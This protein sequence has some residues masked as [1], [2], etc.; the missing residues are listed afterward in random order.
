MTPGRTFTM[1]RTAGALIL[2]VVG[3]A[4]VVLAVYLYALAA[5]GGGAETTPVG[6]VV[7]GSVGGLVGVA[8]L[9][10]AWHA[11]RGPSPT[12][13]GRFRRGA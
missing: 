10:F 6:L 12:R 7:Y 11:I 9:L 4:V 13:R 2:G 5:E 8:F 1:L 3:L